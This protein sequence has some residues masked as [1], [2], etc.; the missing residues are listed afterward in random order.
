LNIALQL[1]NKILREAATIESLHSFYQVV[2]SIFF[3]VVLQLFGE[4]VTLVYHMLLGAFSEPR[5]NLLMDQ[6]L[7]IDR[8]ILLLVEINMIFQSGWPSEKIHV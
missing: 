4:N 5:L 8:S 6:L 3:L 7:F 2:I 1:F